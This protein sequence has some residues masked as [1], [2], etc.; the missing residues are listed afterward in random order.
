MN[1]LKKVAAFFVRLFSPKTAAA[2]VA[3]IQKAAP[4]VSAALELAS[5]VN[6]FA[7]LGKTYGTVAMY[8]DALGLPNILEGEVTEAKVGTAL[9]DLTVMALKAKFPEASTA[10]L[11]RAVEIAV[12]A[13]KNE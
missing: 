9:R 6:K 5:L 8:A 1:W 13:L 11:N 10:D 4:Y 7:P 12:G 2:I 3:G